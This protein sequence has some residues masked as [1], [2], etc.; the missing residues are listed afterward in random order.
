MLEA[1]DPPVDANAFLPCRVAA[2]IGVAHATIF[3]SHLG[4]RTTAAATRAFK[5]DNGLATRLITR[6]R[7]FGC[8]E[9]SER[10]D[11]PEYPCL[12]G[13]SKR[14]RSREGCGRACVRVLAHHVFL[15][16]NKYLLAVTT[17]VLVHK[18]EISFEFSFSG[19]RADVRRDIE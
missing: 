16:D 12:M 8:C 19:V 5:S 4:K 17:L 6:V 13:V 9:R 14:S 1:S 18:T 7:F 3:V 2:T 15:T 10:L 11:L